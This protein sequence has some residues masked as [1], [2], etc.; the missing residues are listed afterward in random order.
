VGTS[1]KTPKSQSKDD[2][3]SI[4]VVEKLPKQ[5]LTVLE[6]TI[7]SQVQKSSLSSSPQDS[8][9][10][11]KETVIF[12]PASLGF[13]HIPNTTP[14][15]QPVVVAQTSIPYSPPP[16]YNPLLA[17]SSPLSRQKKKD[18]SNE[19]VHVIEVRDS[20][21]QTKESFTERYLREVYFGPHHYYPPRASP[22]RAPLARGEAVEMFETSPRKTQVRRV[23]KT[24]ADI[25]VYPKS[26]SSVCS[27]DASTGSLER[28]HELDEDDNNKI[29]SEI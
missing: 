15:Q 12:R 22:R 27:V 13:K 19:D 1:L 28:V 9:A 16:P 2:L 18:S 4:E 7:S 20:A 11:S 21:C 10:E 26:P 6:P 24:S 17:H 3:N 14:Q 5:K 25:L 8:S 29:F 23:P